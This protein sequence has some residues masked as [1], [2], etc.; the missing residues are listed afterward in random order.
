[1]ASIAPKR[2]EVSIKTQFGSKK[3]LSIGLRGNGFRNNKLVIRLLPPDLHESEFLNQLASYYPFHASKVLQFYY[4]KGSYPQ[5]PF[6]LPA[7]SR[8][9][10][11]FKNVPDMTEFSNYLREKPFSD[12]T[13][14]IIPIIEK[15]LFH[16]MVGA[17]Q[18]TPDNGGSGGAKTKS[19]LAKDEIYQYFLSFLNKEIPDFNLI[20]VKKLLKKKHKDDPKANVKVNKKKNKKKKKKLKQKKLEEDTQSR[21]AKGN[22]AQG[23]DAKGNTNQG[24][25]AKGN[26]TQ[27]KDAK[28]NTTQGKDAKGNTNQGKD[29][30]GNT[31]Q[32]K[33]AKGNTTQGKDAKGNTNQGKDA[34]G[35][36]NQGKDA[37]GDTTQGKDAKGKTK[38]NVTK[39]SN[40]EDESANI[41]KKRKLKKPKKKKEVEVDATKTASSVEGNKPSRSKKNRALKKEKAEASKG[42]KNES[43]QINQH[44]STKPV[45]IKPMKILT[46]R[47]EKTG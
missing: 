1:M 32:G 15:S 24:K 14:S 35:N 16:K 26:T 18:T 5:K 46:T 25:D 28:G 31:N 47:D 7:Y 41:A 23:K 13:D 11:S 44:N 6:E 36:T 33:D 37:N 9:Y 30:K 8:A 17:K 2:N 4:V 3:K 19:T 42:N 34:K 39:A 38:K 29:A 22:T 21:D 10:L 45:P 12:D 20:K 40:P 43:S 27:G